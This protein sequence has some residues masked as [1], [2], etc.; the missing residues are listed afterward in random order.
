MM[1]TEQFSL[2]WN[3]HTHHLVDVFKNLLRSES[4]VDVTLSCEGQSLKAHKL[5]LSACSPY[6]ETLFQDHT[7]TH[8]IVILKDVKFTELRSI[9]EFMYKGEVEVEKNDLDSLFSTAEGLMI[10]G[11]T[12]SRPAMGGITPR[13]PAP[14][15]DPVHRKR[16]KPEPFEAGGAEG[17]GERAPPPADGAPTAQ[18]PFSNGDDSSVIKRPK[19]EPESGEENSTDGIESG[20]VGATT[21]LCPE[22]GLSFQS[23]HQLQTHHGA[24][25]APPGQAPLEPSGGERAT[26]VRAPARARPEEA[27]LTPAV[28]SHSWPPHD[29]RERALWVERPGEP[30]LRLPYLPSG[31]RSELRFLPPLVGMPELGPGRGMLGMMPLLGSRHLPAASEFDGRAPL[32]LSATEGAGVGSPT[33]SPSGDRSAPSTPTPA[34]DSA[35]VTCKVCTRVF[36]SPAL[37]RDHAAAHQGDRPFRCE[38]CSK[39]FKFRHHLKDHSRIHTGERPF[40][41]PICKKTFARSSILKTHT[42]IH[43]QEERR[44]EMTPFL[45]AS[46]PSLVEMALPASE[47]SSTGQ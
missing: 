1:G 38:W 14:P 15:D 7:E 16:P 31:L 30:A 23:Q 2:K 5:V 29:G 27:A 11:L 13:Q 34:D 32:N 43:K 47:D 20:G 10:R 33:A 19:L 26:V 46:A 40:E 45:G 17:G 6:F 9:I 21:Y 24:E 28:H 3:N 39:A 42:K 41:C 44:F 4:L 12:G 37:L 8:P 18:A 35:P 22:C 25:H 36:E